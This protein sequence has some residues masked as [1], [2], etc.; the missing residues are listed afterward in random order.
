MVTLNGNKYII[1]FTDYLTKYS[2]G[3]VLYNCKAETVARVFIKKIVLKHGCLIVL[4]LDCAT[5]FTSKLIRQ[6]CKLCNTAKN[7]LPPTIRW[8]MGRSNVKITLWLQSYN[9]QHNDWDEYIP[10]AVFA[11]NNQRQDSTKYLRFFFCMVVNAGCP[12]TLLWIFYQINTP[13][14]WM[15]TQNMS[16]LMSHAWDSAWSNIKNE[17]NQKRQ[18]NQNAQDHEYKIGQ[19]IH[20]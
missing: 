4:Q 1:V 15:T 7:S 2:E 18:Y 3:C 9:K 10:Y 16:Q 12:W 5:N 20:T 6:I 17:Q 14:M 13:S 8:Q 19:R 11:Y